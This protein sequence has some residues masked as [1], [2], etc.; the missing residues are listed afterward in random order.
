MIVDEL[1]RLRE[2]A[3]EI[4]DRQ[5]LIAVLES[6]AEKVT[7]TLDGLPNSGSRNKSRLEELTILLV[8]ARSEQA[9]AEEERSELECRVWSELVKLP[10]GILRTVIVDRYI[11]NKSWSAIS[12]A[13]K[14]SRSRV[15]Q[16]HAEALRK[17]N[18]HWT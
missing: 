2:L 14:K 4:G 10:R 12:L 7:P 18:S 16:L 15:F 9:A 13:L 5:E 11:E 3:R 1:K 6:R 17:L 8:E